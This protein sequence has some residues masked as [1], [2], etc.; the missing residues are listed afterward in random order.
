MLSIPKGGN[1]DETYEGN[2]KDGKLN[3][4][5]RIRCVDKFTTRPIGHWNDQQANLFYFSYF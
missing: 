5:A 1:S 2:W 4:H 3:G